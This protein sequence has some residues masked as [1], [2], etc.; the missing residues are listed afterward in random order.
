M[1]CIKT[2]LFNQ[3]LISVPFPYLLFP[4][5]NRNGTSFSSE[6]PSFGRLVTDFFIHLAVE[7]FFFYYSHRILHFKSVYGH[8]HKV[9]HQFKAPIGIASEF[10]HPIEFVVSNMFPVLLGP[11]ITS[12]HIMNLW[13]WMAIVISATINGHSGY[14]F[15]FSPFG[16]AYSHDFHHSSFVDNYGALG[17]LDWIHSTNHSYRESFKIKKNFETEN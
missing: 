4:L 15:S 1:R 14:L 2:V 5:Y 13:L 8:I 10:A 17:F 3:I 6:L 9:H 7:E 11:I 16:Y 12:T